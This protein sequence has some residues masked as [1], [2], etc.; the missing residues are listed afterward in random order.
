MAHFGYRSLGINFN[1]LLVLSN[2]FK[3]H[4]YKSDSIILYNPRNREGGSLRY[5]R[6]SE[7]PL[8][9]E[10]CWNHLSNVVPGSEEEASFQFQYGFFPYILAFII[11]ATYMAQVT[12]RSST[13]N[14]MVNVLAYVI[15]GLEEAIRD[16]MAFIIKEENRP[17]RRNSTIERMPGI[18]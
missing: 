16:M 7:V 11:I 14:R 18:L 15:E 8:L 4:V 3:K 2:H 1:P 17:D 9:T 12:W 10:Y 6:F 5:D 13:L